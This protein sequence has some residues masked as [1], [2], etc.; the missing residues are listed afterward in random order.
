MRMILN[1]SL[2]LSLNLL[3]C[4]NY[5]NCCMMYIHT[6]STRDHSYQLLCIFSWANSTRMYRHM[7]STS[8]STFFQQELF[9]IHVHGKNI[10]SDPPCNYVVYLCWFRLHS[11]KAMDKLIGL[12]NCS[13]VSAIH[14]LNQPREGYL[15]STM[16]HKH[17]ILLY[18]I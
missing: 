11:T 6:L 9:H 13:G 2:L 4:K 5:Q 3:T 7:Y 8:E 1:K 14:C 12:L 16:K 17:Y 18:S 15:V 10:F